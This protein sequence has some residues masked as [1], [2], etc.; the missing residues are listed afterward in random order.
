MSSKDDS[1]DIPPRAA[2]SFDIRFMQEG[3]YSTFLFL[4]KK[5][6]ASIGLVIAY[7]GN[8]EGVF[9]SLL[10]GLIEAEV[11][12][13]KVREV[14]DWKRQSFKQ[15]RRIFKDICN[16]WLAQSHS[17]TARKLCKISDLSGDLQRQRNMIAHGTYVYSIKPY[18][19][20]VENCS[21]VNNKTGDELPFDDWVL[22]KL[23]H[24]ISHLT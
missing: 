19:S 8:F 20:E 23:Y 11:A 13:G 14:S 9:D 4:P 3:K 21:A 15:R 1:K 6:H 12:D 22:K 17:D 18:S 24:D 10:A 5:Y 7:W 16:N 2:V